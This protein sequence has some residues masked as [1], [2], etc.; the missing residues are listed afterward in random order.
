MDLLFR[1]DRDVL[2]H[3]LLRLFFALVILFLLNSAAQAQYCASGATSTLDSY[4]GNVQ[5]AG[6]GNTLNNASTGCAQYTDYTAVTPVPDLTPSSSYTVNVTQATCGSDYTRYCNVWIDFNGDGDFDDANEMLGTGTTG[7]ATA[8]FVWAIGFTV[9]AGATIGTTRMRVSINEGTITD[10]CQSYTWGE[11]EDYTVEIVTAGP[12]TYASST[13]T[14]NNTGSV[15][16]CAS[17]AE[18]LGV[19][20]V[21]TGST[22]PLSC[23]QLRVNMNGTTNTGDVSNISVYYTGTSSTFAATTLFGTVTPG[24]GNLLVNGSQALSSGT[25]YFW[26]VYTINGTPAVGNA[27]DARCNRVTVGGTDFTPTVANPAVT[28][29]FVVCT[30][31]P[32]GVSANLQSWVRADNG[33]GTTTDGTTVSTWTDLSGQGNSGTGAG[34]TRPV[35][36]RTTASDANFNPGIEFDGTDD[37]L[38]LPNNTIATGGGAYSI[39]TVCSPGSEHVAGNPGKIVMA[40]EFNLFSSANLWVAI[41]VRSNMAVLH[42][43]NQN[44]LTSA[45]NMAVQDEPLILSNLYDFSDATRRESH[46]ISQMGTNAATDNPVTNHNNSGVNNLI[47]KASPNNEWYDGLVQEVIIYDGKHTTT[48][49]YPIESYLGVKY[50]LTLDHNYIAADGS[51]V[52]WDR[53]ANAGYNNNITGI[54]RDDATGL[55]QRQ[56][57]SENTGAMLTIGNST[58]LAADN[59]ANANSFAASGSYL[60]WGNNGASNSNEGSADIGFTTNAV[61]IVGRMDRIWKA[62]ET[63]TVGTVIIR[64]DMSTVSSNTGPGNNDLNDVRLLVDGDGTFASGALAISPTSVNNTTDIVEFQHDFAAGTGFFFTIGT[65]DLNSAPLPVELIEFSGEHRSGVNHLAWST[66]VEIE[67]DY[68]TLERSFDGQEFEPFATV[69]GAGNSSSTRFYFETD[70]H[71]F[72]PVTYYR[73]RQTDFDGTETLSHIVAL[74]SKQ[75]LVGDPVLWPNPSEGE[76]LFLMDGGDEQALTLNIFDGVGKLIYTKQYSSLIPGTV[77]RIDG[78]DWPNGIYYVEFLSGNLRKG[79]RLVIQH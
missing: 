3:S 7:D 59:L 77:Q 75:L 5:L 79:Q 38:D 35:F 73:L 74:R 27:L 31:S 40:G 47:G 57:R 53:T 61:N 66:A 20:V 11:T 58:T 12:M 6:D 62:Q 33:A 68:F 15:Q 41:D 49:R 76:V 29:D 13:A 69:D 25:N 51:T 64:V 23:T 71:P 65:I 45:N 39:Y 19:E 36:R 70:H 67:N 10:P 1:R 72:A 37:F 26:V 28:R 52:T 78:K 4:V 48:D 2:H 21:T 55:D 50:G 30:G 22:S 17:S 60:L 63:G 16:N 34:T 46:M 43:F 8:G 32:G 18:I 44:D 54:G 24:A 9:P 42:G 56:S 14:Q